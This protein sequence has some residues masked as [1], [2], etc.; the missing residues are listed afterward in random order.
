MVVHARSGGTIEVMGLMQG[1]TDGDA[2]IVMDDFALPVE[3]TETRVNAQADA[4]E[5]MVDAS[6]PSLFRP[7]LILFS[8]SSL[9]LLRHLSL[10]QFWGFEQCRQYLKQKVLSKDADVD[11]EMAEMIASEIKSL[12]NQLLVFEEKLKMLLIPS[13]PL[14]TRNILLEVRAGTGGEEAGLWVADLVRMYQR[15][16]ER[17]SLKYSPLSC[18]EAERGGYKTYVMEVKGARVYSKLKYESGVHRVQRVP[19]TEA[20]GRIHTSTATVAIMPEGNKLTGQGN[21]L[22]GKIPEVIGLMQALAVL[23]LCENELVGSIPP[24]FG[25]LS[26]TGKLYLHANR[27]TG[28]IPPELGNMT[29]LSYLYNL[30]P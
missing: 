18:S 13:D 9:R 1:K 28:P 5:Y 21:K 15:Y 29:K 16:A 14:D 22:T 11:E 2:I 23:D 17:N 10:N 4:Y 20:Q 26:F 25:N 19:Q 7:P 12:S 27:L 3:G 24:I 8:S 6:P 30:R